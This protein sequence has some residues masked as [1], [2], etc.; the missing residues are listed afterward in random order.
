MSTSV[1]QIKEKLS[2]ED[3]IGS[4]IKLE[5]AGNS[6]KAR[7]PFHN[8]K[9]PSFFVSPDRGGYYCFGCGVKGDVFTFVQ[10]FEGIDFVGAL[11]ILADRAGVQL[12]KI[13]P[14]VADKKERLYYLLEVTTEFLEKNLQNEEIPLDYLKKRGLTEKT[15]K[16][17]RI[18]YV[19][20][21]WRTIYEHLKSKGFLDEEMERAGMIKTEGQN[22]YDRF[23]GRIMFPLFDSAGRVIAFS[24]RIMPAFDDGKAGKYLNSPQT[25]IF[26]KSKTLY[27]FD[28]AKLSIRK[29]DFSVLVEGQMDIIMSHQAGFTNTVASSGTALTAE[30]LKLLKRIS[31]RI[32]MSFD[33][34]NAGAKAAERGWALALASGMEVKVAA[35]PKGYD[36]ADLILKNKEEFK[37][38]LKNA[39][40]IIDFL[41]ERV[42][43]E[44]TD[45]RKI[46]I[47]IKNKVLPY[48]SLIDSNIEKS[49][50][51]SKISGRTG[52]KEEAIWDDLK[53]VKLDEDYV[54][55]S[56]GST[57]SGQAKEES[58][59]KTVDILPKSSAERS[60]ASIIALEESR[61]VKVL[62]PSLVREKVKNILKSDEYDLLDENIKKMSGELAFEAESYYGD[63]DEVKF[64]KELDYIL[65]NLQEDI[66][67]KELADLMLELKKAEHAKEN[68]KAISILQRCNEITKKLHQIKTDRNKIKL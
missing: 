28:R 18:G 35:I 62:D 16:D 37:E 52:I 60:L 12:E 46:G 32:I 11:K 56:T 30:H 15:I 26:D 59:E 67:K 25:E 3:V 43:Q 64:N 63:L 22:T 8:E 55:R 39:V 33:S 29:L 36:P 42:Y 44:N 45:E 20:N 2:I 27:G 68:D 21:E 41:L 5:R 54:S 17:W 24:G 13:S 58:V 9:T 38:V 1:E 31:N 49:H 50:Y 23:R 57:S 4:Y 34:D 19:R 51:V 47:A 6:L 65:L 40:H 7:C 10:E 66:F 53:K 14:K 48:L 61:K